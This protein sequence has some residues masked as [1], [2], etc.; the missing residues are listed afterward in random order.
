M[1]GR[2]RAGIPLPEPLLAMTVHVIRCPTSDEVRLY[3][4]APFGPLTVVIRSLCQ[5]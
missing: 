1:M 3:S 4:F 2:L 5:L